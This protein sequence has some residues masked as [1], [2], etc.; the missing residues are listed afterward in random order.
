MKWFI[1]LVAIVLLLGAVLFALLFTPPGNRI[2]GAIIESKLNEKLPLSSKLEQFE[3]SYD[4][5]HI[6]LRLSPE[7]QISITGNYG[8]FSQSF[9]IAYNI[10]LENLETLEVLSRQKLYGALRTEGKVVGN[11]KHF[12][13][14]GSSDIADSKSSYHL[15]IDDF[16][17]QSIQADIK[18]AKT[19]K[20]LAM[21]GKAPYALSLLNLQA[22]MRSL[23]PASLQGDFK[24]TLDKGRIDTALMQRDFNVSL[25]KTTF[26]MSSSATLAG[27]RVNYTSALTSNLA[28]ITSNG[29]IEPE[30]LN[31][32]L[33]YALKIA[34]LEL[35]KPLTNAPLR[36]DIIVKG[37][38]KGT[39]EKL[40]VKATSDLAK[41]NTTINAELREFKPKSLQAD[42][43]KLSLER[44][45]YMIEQ[46]HYLNG[47]MLDAVITL[48][49]ASIEHL[50]GKVT[51][52][53]TGGKIDVAT[54]QEAFE[55][56]HMPS[57]T[58]NTNTV[59]T[60]DPSEIVTTLQAHSNV[61]TLNVPN[62]AFYPKTKT[63]QSD[64]NAT[65]HDLNLL[66]FITKQ[67]IRGSLTC[68]GEIVKDKALKVT[69]DSSTLGGNIHALFEN[70]HL[71]ASL[72]NLE[73]L[74][75]LHMLYYPEVFASTLNGTLQYTLKSKSGTLDATM[76]KGRF[77]QNA[78]GDLLKKHAKYNLYKERVES[79]LSSTIEPK[80]IRSNLSMK[81]GS[82]SINDPKMQLYTESQQIKS[83][84]KI[85]ANNNPLII[86]LRGDVKKPKVSIDASEL[87]K[88]EAGKAVKKELNKLIKDLF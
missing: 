21:A 52:V 3:L 48:N 33:N 54:V 29:M 55:F 5:L 37:T 51:T 56:T 12:S 14:E 27:K 30:T 70:N 62:A 78:M 36:G 20:L 39:K 47:G 49:N 38:A 9:D 87:I 82:I 7:N 50:Q 13:V 59:S 22:D 16:T 11:I 63:L 19:D 34:K 86:K 53:V 26:A 67:K 23:D 83:N 28:T 58:F 69:F 66:Q 15:I 68:K 31:M 79:T 18:N 73:T 81:G 42:I 8:L 17:P 84:L 40:Y 45:L 32:D 6:M 65:F 35:F 24:L 46:P 25:P 1:A 75:M 85:T 60:L 80:L 57:I 2:T 74:K 61:I 76:S 88:R 10:R 41:S 4:A 64:Y 43:K 44:L 77:T 72:N 71:N